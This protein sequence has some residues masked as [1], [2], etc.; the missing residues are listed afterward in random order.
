M[1]NR[2]HAQTRSIPKK[3]SRPLNGGHDPHDGAV[4]DRH[5]TVLAGRGWRVT[6]TSTRHDDWRRLSS[7]TSTARLCRQRELSVE[8]AGCRADS[9]RRLGGVRRSRGLAGW[10]AAWVAAVRNLGGAHARAQH[11]RRRG[12]GLPVCRGEDRRRP[13]CGVCRCGDARSRDGSRGFDEFHDIGDVD[14]VLGLR[15][16]I[17]SRREGALG[18]G[19]RRQR[20]PRRQCRGRHV[21]PQLREPVRPPGT[22]ERSDVPGRPADLDPVAPRSAPLPACPRRS[23]PRR[24]S[25]LPCPG[26]PGTS[27]SPHSVAVEALRPARLR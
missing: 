7:L 22:H 5:R 8:A 26:E 13:R 21:C 10:S 23:R 1:S 2:S 14:D 20:P 4:G 19:V 17:L 18:D 24:A 15:Y 11:S 6:R 25:T 16:R 9:A 12:E 27:T 3:Q